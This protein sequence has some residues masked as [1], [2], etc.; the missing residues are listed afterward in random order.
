MGQSRRG[1][2]LCGIDAAR[3]AEVERLATY[4]LVNATLLSVLELQRATGLRAELFQVFMLIAIATVQRHVRAAGPDDPL[5]DNTP[6][7]PEHSG[8]ISRR[9]IAET[10]GIPLETV[11]RHVAALLERGLIVERGRGRISTPGGTLARVGASGA[12][13]R[14]ARQH[15]AT[16]NTL[17]RLGVTAPA[18]RTEARPAALRHGEYQSASRQI[19]IDSPPSS[20]SSSR[21]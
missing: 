18:Q 5:A 11:R 14:I 19:R 1:G 6:L 20:D 7:G 15:V 4:E 13:L 3:F 9:R 2:P 16:S 8:T 10:L 17:A 12:T 21:S